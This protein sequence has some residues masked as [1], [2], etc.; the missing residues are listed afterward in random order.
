MGK[1]AKNGIEKYIVRFPHKRKI[2][3]WRDYVIPTGW[4]RKRNM[5][6][7]IAG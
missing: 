6:G 2:L 7:N 5:S 4:K 1:A 3:D